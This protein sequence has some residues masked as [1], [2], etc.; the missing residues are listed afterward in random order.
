MSISYK[1]YEIYSSKII[2]NFSINYLTIYNDFSLWVVV[3][4]RK[5]DYL[6]LQYEYESNYVDIFFFYIIRRKK[7]NNNSTNGIF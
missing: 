1:S 6:K 3:E 5:I 7:R 2:I 4:E